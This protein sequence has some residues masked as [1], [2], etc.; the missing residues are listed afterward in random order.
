MS[1][2][3]SPKISGN[4]QQTSPP[5]QPPTSEY[6]RKDKMIHNDQDTPSNTTKNPY[7]K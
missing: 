4:T 3:D 7:K 5:G 6:V 2:N 1:E